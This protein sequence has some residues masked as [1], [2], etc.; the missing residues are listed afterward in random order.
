MAMSHE[1]AVDRIRKMFSSLAIPDYS[2]RHPELLPA[3]DKLSKDEID[4]GQIEAILADALEQ[5]NANVAEFRNICKD[6][7]QQGKNHPLAKSRLR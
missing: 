5:S 7:S 4:V 6:I 2:E 3:R 1:G